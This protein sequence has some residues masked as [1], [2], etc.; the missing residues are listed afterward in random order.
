MTALRTLDW[1]EGGIGQLE[2]S[3]HEEAGGRHE[4]SVDIR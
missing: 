1:V 3:R 4:L 2:K